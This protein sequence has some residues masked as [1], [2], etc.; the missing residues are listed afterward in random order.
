VRFRLL[1]IDERFFELFADAAANAADAARP[2]REVLAGEPGGLERIVGCERRGDE[3][4]RELLRR[5]DTSFVTP[6]DRADT[7]P[8]PRSSTT[9]W[10]MCS[11]SCTSSSSATAS[12]RP[13]PS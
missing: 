9:S 2:L 1:P 3:I 6:F 7:T 4:T 11:R 10:T 12:P 13:F 5:L 8:S